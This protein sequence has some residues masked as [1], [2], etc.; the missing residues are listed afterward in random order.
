MHTHVLKIKL[1]VDVPLYI[2]STNVVIL[3]GLVSL[4]KATAANAEAPIASTVDT[5]VEDAI[6]F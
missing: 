3:A 2:L 1:S 4:Y 6:F 5:N